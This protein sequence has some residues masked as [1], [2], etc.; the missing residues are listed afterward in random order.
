LGFKGAAGELEIVALPGLRFHVN[1]IQVA[2]IGI[3]FDMPLSRWI[4]PN[5][6]TQGNSNE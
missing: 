3:D 4:A 6:S 1:K 5:P 2:Y